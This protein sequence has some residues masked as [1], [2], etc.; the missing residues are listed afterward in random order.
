VKPRAA[1]KPVVARQASNLVVAS[2]PIQSRDYEGT[3]FTEAPGVLA[4]AAHKTGR[5]KSD[6]ELKQITKQEHDRLKALLL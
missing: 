1:S 5:A 6:F 3:G 2:E 4:E